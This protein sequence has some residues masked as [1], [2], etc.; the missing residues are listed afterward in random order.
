MKDVTKWDDVSFVNS[1][2]YRKRV[3][4]KLN[5]PKTPSTLSK[6]TDINKTHISKTLSELESKNLVECLTKNAMKS[7]LYIISDYGKDILKEVEKL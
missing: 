1:S 5:S 4:T 6:E 7:K 3:L 2:T